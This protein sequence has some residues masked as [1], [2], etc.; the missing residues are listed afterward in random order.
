MPM[1]L[2]L[3]CLWAL[4]ANILAM[5]PSRDRHWR[6]AYLLIAVGIPIVGYVTWQTGPFMGFICLLAAVSIL[7]I[8]LKKKQLIAPAAADNS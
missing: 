5:T 3:A 4:A 1:S 2:I 8:H 7:L 6:A